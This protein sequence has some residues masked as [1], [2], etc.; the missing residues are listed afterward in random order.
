MATDLSIRSG[1]AN[2]NTKFQILWDEAIE[3]AD[4]GPYGQWTQDI[5]AGGA[6][7]TTIGFLAN[8]PGW[9]RWRGSKEVKDMR[10]YTQSITYEKF[11][12]TMAQPRDLVE[13]DQ[14]GALN[15]ALQSWISQNVTDCYDTFVAESFDGNSGAG[16]TG[17]D[18]VSLFSASHPHAPSGATQSNLG[19][20]TNLSHAAL[21]AVEAAGGLM[22]QENGRPLRLDYNVCRVG[23]YLKRRAL[24]LFSTDRVVI[25]NQAGVTDTL[26][27]TTSTDDINAAATRS[28]TFANTMQVV[29]DHRVTTYYTTFIDTRRGFKPMVLFK[30][31]APEP[32]SQTDM[33]SPERFNFDNYMYSVEAD[34]GVASGHWY[35]AYRLTGTA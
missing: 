35:S 32:I 34:F 10:T 33:D 20:G 29:V 23:P 2:H 21:R 27:S 17:F 1:L 3:S 16:P 31:R 25:V 8:L 7:S 14:T 11:H 30:V 26:R 15:A 5:D 4:P 18:A 28:N 13:G 12:S 24:E 19:S 22:V 9:V 6:Q